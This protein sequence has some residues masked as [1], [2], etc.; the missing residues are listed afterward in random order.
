MK[1][2]PVMISVSGNQILVGTEVSWL[3]KTSFPNRFSFIFRNNIFLI[4][5]FFNFFYFN[6]I[7]TYLYIYIAL[8]ILTLFLQANRTNTYNT[9]II[10]TENLKSPRLKR[11]STFHICSVLQISIFL[12]L[13]RAGAHEPS[14]NQWYNKRG[15]KYFESL[16]TISFVFAFQDVLLSQSLAEEDCFFHIGSRKVYLWEIILSACMYM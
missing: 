14:Q 8:L 10:Y 9:S 2:V 1:I 11:S 15:R 13:T 12:N 7:L 6:I 3:F 5:F 16:W 4:L